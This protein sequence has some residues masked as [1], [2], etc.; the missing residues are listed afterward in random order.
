MN[1]LTFLEA[2]SQNNNRDWFETHR[3]DY[4]KAKSELIVMVDG[5]ISE[6]SKFDPSIEN[7]ES[8]KCL[9]RINRDIRFSHDKSPYKLFMSAFMAKD[10]KS[11]QSAGYYIHFEPGK[12]FVGGGIYSPQPLV[13]QAIRNE[14]YF[15]SGDFYTIIEND[16]FKKT[17]GALMDEKY[18]RIPKGFPTDFPKGE[19][20]KY[21]HYVA[22]CQIPD[23]I[24]QLS[25]I[26]NFAIG[27]FKE[28]YPLNQFL[29][30]SILNA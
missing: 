3:K 19:L 30:R 10:G 4:E 14:I 18:T 2:L 23:E 27:V 26:Q 11:S 8:K 21:K 25:D 13:Q 29:C 7:L 6:I 20:L 12:S 28:L 16:L 9:F 17:F 22:S 1:I 5:L 24:S 15:N